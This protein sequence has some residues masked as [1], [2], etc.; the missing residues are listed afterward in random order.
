MIIV[1]KREIWTRQPTEP[2]DIDWSNPLAK[3]LAFANPLRPGVG[4]TDL[5]QKQ[6]PAWIGDSAR[7]SNKYGEFAKTG[8]QCLSFAKQP[9]IT[10][11]QP[12]SI[13]WIQ[14]PSSVS[15]Y[16]TAMEFNVGGGGAFV[17]GF[18]S[19]LSAFY[20]MLC[21]F[22]NGLTEVSYW[23]MLGPPVVGQANIYTAVFPDGVGGSPTNCRLYRDGVGYARTGVSALSANNGDH[24]YIGARDAENDR[25]YGLLGNVLIH[26]RA[27][28][29]GEAKGLHENSWQ[30]YKRR[31]RHVFVGASGGGG[32]DLYGVASGTSQASGTATLSAQVALAG[33]GVSI[34]G[35]SA[36]ASATVP[37]SATGISVSGGDA[38]LAATIAIAAAGLAQAAGAA[39][40]SASVLL[41]GS[42]A[43]LAAGNATL[44]AQLSALASGSAQA[45]GSATLSGGAPGAISAF[46]TSVAGGSG[47]LEVTVQLAAT[48]TAQASG[49]A[50]LSGGPEGEIAASGGA[51]AGGSG[52][53]AV[54]VALTAA[55][56]VQAMGA[57]AMLV[58]VHLAATGSATAGGSAVLRLLG[59]AVPVLDL[60]YV[61]R[62]VRR[63]YTVLYG[64]G[65]RYELESA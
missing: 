34:A 47:T 18:Q 54:T 46:G 51:V 17:V 13:T 16:H 10:H 41:A 64:Q 65:S 53:L 28:D 24:F 35:G 49:T 2:V 5:I 61:A 32:A 63:D 12:C 43:A 8:S 39:G 25:F 36:T 15:G 30:I 45:S 22:R 40:L 21:G 27:L 7:G 4:M 42:G 11:T 57:G 59:A 48:G 37:I 55:G 56:F 38:N 44:A 1:P 14:E 60:R 50:T 29:E 9:Q 26:G 31:S 3:G 6:E 23:D 20:Y 52:T 19:A 33:V 62:A 58:S